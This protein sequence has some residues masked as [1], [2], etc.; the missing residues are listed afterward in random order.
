MGDVDPRVVDLSS[1]KASL[2]F[3]VV[4]EIVTDL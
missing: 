3:L 2:P 1:L 4:L